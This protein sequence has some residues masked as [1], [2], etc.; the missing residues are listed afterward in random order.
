M[1]LTYKPYVQFSH[2][3]FFL[4]IGAPDF[5]VGTHPYPYRHGLAQMDKLELSTWYSILTV[6]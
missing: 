5:S 1:P 3:V 4:S 6:F 2:S